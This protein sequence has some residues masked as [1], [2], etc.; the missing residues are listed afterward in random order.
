MKAENIL[1]GEASLQYCSGF[2]WKSCWGKGMLE[3]FPEQ[4]VCS[5]VCWFWGYLLAIFSEG[6]SPANAGTYRE[7]FFCSDYIYS[8]KDTSAVI[9]GLW[10]RRRKIFHGIFHLE[11]FFKKSVNADTDF[12]LRNSTVPY[13]QKLKQIVIIRDTSKSASDL[14][15]TMNIA[16]WAMHVFHPSHFVCTWNDLYL[17][18]WHQDRIVRWLGSS[19]AEGF[20]VLW[21]YCKEENW[22]LLV[23]FWSHSTEEAVCWFLFSFL[24]QIFCIAIVLS[25]LW[26]MNSYCAVNEICFLK[27]ACDQYQV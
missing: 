6:R 16:R 19:G 8:K 25:S 21:W 4:I 18:Q 23:Y 26:L 12:S 13:F 5:C 7:M 10:A 9:D 14:I 20:S 17:L 22:Y 27:T 1:T 11:Y 24:I 3:S 2:Q 15:R